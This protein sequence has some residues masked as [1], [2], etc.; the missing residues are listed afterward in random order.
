ME[1]KLFREDKELYVVAKSAGRRQKEIAI[2]R[3]KLARLLWTLRGMRRE[4]SRDRL[5]QR[6]GAARQKAGRAAG[7]VTVQVPAADQPVSRETF[8]FSV[9]QEKLADAEL[10]DGHYLLRSNLAEEDPA[11]LWKLYLLL[12]EIEGVFRSF[13][14]DLQVRPIY[15]SV[16]QRVEAHIFVSFLAYCLWVTLQQ[17][18]RA[19]APGLTPRQALDQ[20]AGVQMLDVV[21]PTTDGRTL[22]LSRHTQPEAGVRLLL[23]QLKLALPEQPPPRLSAA[24]K[25]EVPLSG[26]SEDLSGTPPEK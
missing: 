21:M 5:L 20:L 1:V 8:R 18:L 3:K 24:Q 14:N 17:R 2:R 12:V 4:K 11:W 9:L 23:Q 15:H 13:K 26:C 22:V 25:L 6:L 10:D 16:E 19:L 7:F